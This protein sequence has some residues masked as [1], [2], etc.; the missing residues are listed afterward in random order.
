MPCGAASLRVPMESVW[1]VDHGSVGTGGSVI[2]DDADQP[3]TSAR[4]LVIRFYDRLWNHWDDAEVEDILAPDITFRGSLGQTTVGCAGWHS[5]RDDIRYHRNVR[6]GA[7]SSRVGAVTSFQGRQ[8]SDPSI[9]E[10]NLTTTDLGSIG[11]GLSSAAFKVLAVTIPSALR[12]IAWTS[13]SSLTLERLVTP[14]TRRRRR[15]EI[16]VLW[17]IGQTMA[18]RIEILP[19]KLR[20]YNVCRF[21]G[22]VS[23]RHRPRCSFIGCPSGRRAL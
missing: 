15:V 14:S 17:P 2:A 5:Y 12:R 22:L 18:I 4:G 20:T 3:P 6:H 10:R 1:V 16:S 19:P 21:P 11:S 23:N 7:A 8:N 9:L 13:R